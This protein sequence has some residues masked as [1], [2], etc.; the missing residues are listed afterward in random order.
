MRDET[1]REIKDTAAEILKIN[2]RLERLSERQIQHINNRSMTRAK[3]TTYNANA[4]HY[5]E[6]R[7]S[8]R[9]ELQ[10]L[11]KE[12]LAYSDPAFANRVDHAGDSP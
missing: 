1:M 6:A 7:D 12:F 11:C 4:S 3:T 5:A 2:K 8:H 9:K 10:R